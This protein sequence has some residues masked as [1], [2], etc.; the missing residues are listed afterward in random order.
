MNVVRVTLVAMAAMTGA[1]A[2]ESEIVVGLGPDSKGWLEVFEGQDFPHQG[3]FQLTWSDYNSSSGEARVAC[4]ELDADG[5][6]ELVIGLDSS[7]KG[8]LEVRDDSATGYAHLAWIRIPWSLYNSANG[9]SWPAVGDVDGD[10]KDELVIGL[11]TSGEGWFYVCDDAGQGY[12]SLAWKQV[13]WSSY[14]GANGASRPACGDVDG[15]GKD[16]VVVGLGP[17]PTGGGLVGSVR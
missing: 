12:S 16:E 11:G 3:W 13:N 2:S 9:E 7:G 5:R 14:N 10:G 8:W 15:D 1:Y 6:D 4:G 17:Y